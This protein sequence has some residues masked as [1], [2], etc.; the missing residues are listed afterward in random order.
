M[1]FCTGSIAVFVISFP[2]NVE[3]GPALGTSNTGCGVIDDQRR[4]TTINAS[5]FD[6]SH[7]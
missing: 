2:Y 3:V 5:Q 7:I 1:G 4:S 6:I